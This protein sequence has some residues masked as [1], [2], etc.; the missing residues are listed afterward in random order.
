MHSSL[1]RVNQMN[2]ES[3]IV[4]TILFSIRMGHRCCSLHGTKFKI[5]IEWTGVQNENQFQWKI[6][7]SIFNLFSTCNDCSGYLLFCYK[8][9]SHTWKLKKKSKINRPLFLL[10]S[11]AIMILKVMRTIY[12][13]V[14]GNPNDY[15]GDTFMIFY[16]FWFCLI[17]WYQFRYMSRSKCTNFWAHCFWNG[18]LNCKKTFPSINFE[19]ELSF[20]KLIF[21]ILNR[22]DVDTNQQCIVN[23]SNLNEELG[24]VIF[25]CN[26]YIQTHSFM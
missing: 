25:R 7:Q 24:Q 23:T 21:T 22:Y 19:I 26:F 17:I 10:L 9:V 8:K 2:S 13:W 5:S 12:I 1:F 6:H 14:N 4:S 11:V 20:V 15:F 3:I 16:H 18:I